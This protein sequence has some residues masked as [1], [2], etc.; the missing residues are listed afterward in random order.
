MTKA[1]DP[2]EVPWQD[3]F[4]LAKQLFDD[5]IG[6]MTRASDS[7]EGKSDENGISYLLTNFGGN[8]YSLLITENDKSLFE[9]KRENIW[10]MYYKNSETT[11]GMLDILAD[12]PCQPEHVTGL[13]TKMQTE[14][15]QMFH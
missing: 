14:L 5:G 3:S 12:K 2:N 15:K 8:V 11:F 9:K 6:W 4:K 1:L 10:V 7:W 13:L